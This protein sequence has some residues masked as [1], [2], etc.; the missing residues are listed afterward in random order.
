MERSRANGKEIVAKTKCQHELKTIME[1][2]ESLPTLEK[3]LILQQPIIKTY[4]T[5][6]EKIYV[7]LHDNSYIYHRG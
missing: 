5:E 2:T 6:T 4:N 1:M 3:A 7:L